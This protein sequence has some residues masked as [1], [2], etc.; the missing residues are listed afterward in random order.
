MSLSNSSGVTG[1]RA[2]D[3]RMEDSQC[4]TRQNPINEDKRINHPDRE[5]QSMTARSGFKGDDSP[6]VMSKNDSQSLELI[7]RGNFSSAD[8]PSLGDVGG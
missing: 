6:S 1:P 4:F 8:I 2:L 5:S 3:A 7:F